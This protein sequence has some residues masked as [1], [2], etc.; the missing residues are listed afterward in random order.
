MKIEEII[1]LV[2]A[3]ITLSTALISL[4]VILLKRRNKEGGTNKTINMNNKKN[5]DSQN[6]QIQ[7]DAKNVNINIA[8]AENHN[9]SEIE[10]NPTN[11]NSKSSNSGK[12]TENKLA[13]EYTSIFAEDNKLKT[14]TIK[15]IV[16]EN[17]KV[18]GEVFLNDYNLKNGTAKNYSYKMIGTFSNKVLTA[19]YYSNS[20]K[21]ERGVINLKMI[22]DKILSGFC[23]FSK[24]SP[25][26][27]EIR[28]SPYV[29]VE[30][31]KDNDILN[32]TFSFCTECFVQHKDC[33]CSS[34]KVD[35][36]IFAETEI[37]LLRNQL[38]KKNVSKDIYSKKLQEP[39]QGTCIRQML[40]EN[41][42]VND[43]SV[44]RCHFFDIND[45]KCKIY[46]GR[47][48]DCRLFPFDIRL[49]ESKSQYIIGYYNELCENQLPNYTEMKKY[50]H[51]LRPYFFLM[52]PYLHIITN[53]IVCEKLKDAD[54]R[55]IANFKDFIF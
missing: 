20:S 32:G 46:E 55:K 21:D 29:W 35:M 50:A 38:L 54:F 51:I 17:D 44:S 5:I 9:N 14:E 15:I 22:D 39:Y 26:E 16:Q 36:P 3:V 19:D 30:G 24:L 27:D 40:R 34:D 6:V 41:E 28:L 53:D 18:E 31:A 42:L 1:G 23:S 48:I 7:T 10:K 49:D 47:P 52:Y 37:D 2:A 43:K 8:S 11:S 45:K 33:C 4:V 25:A 12:L 13:K